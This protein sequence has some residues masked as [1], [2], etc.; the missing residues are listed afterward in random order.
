MDQG[1]ETGPATE[2][3]LAR[4]PFTKAFLTREPDWDI[5]G[6]KII[7]LEIK[8]NRDLEKAVGKNWQHIGVG[9]LAIV[10]NNLNIFKDGLPPATKNSLVRSVV[11]MGYE[12]GNNEDSD[13]LLAIIALRLKDMDLLNPDALAGETERLT[14]V[15]LIQGLLKTGIYYR[16]LS[17]YQLSSSSNTPSGPSGDTDPPIS[18]PF[19]D[20]LKT[21]LPK[22]PLP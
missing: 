21:I 7:P 9:A 15:G 22:K 6:K 19:A 5:W 8:V 10:A 18:P 12:I 16:E 20:F 11:E 17:T 4:S 2:N 3:I 14:T 1:K 13:A